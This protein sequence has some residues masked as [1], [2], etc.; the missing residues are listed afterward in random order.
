MSD[1]GGIIGFTL[2]ELGILL[3]FS[4]LFMIGLQ[5]RNNAEPPPDESLRETIELLRAKVD[6]LESV[7]DSLQSAQI[8]SCREKGVVSGFLFDVTVIGDQ[9]FRVEGRTYPSLESLLNRFQESMEVAEDAGC[10]HQ[11]RV[12][13]EANVGLPEYRAAVKRLARHFYYL[14][15]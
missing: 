5:R 9:R 4:L 3:A 13:P 10:I 1:K 7:L 11:I 8:P 12:R 6:S 2:G 15:A 14:E